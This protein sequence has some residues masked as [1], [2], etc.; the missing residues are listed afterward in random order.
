MPSSV[1]PPSVGHGF[2]LGLNAFLLDIFQKLEESE[3]DADHGKGGP[4]PTH[5]GMIRCHA[6]SRPGQNSCQFGLCL[7]LIFPP[8]EGRFAFRKPGTGEFCWGTQFGF[9][10]TPARVFLSLHAH[11]LLFSQDPEDFVD[12]GLVIDRLPIKGYGS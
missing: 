7:T 4:D 12:E 2:A 5:K 10:D 11:I 3:P 6:G 8:P 1:L 9:M